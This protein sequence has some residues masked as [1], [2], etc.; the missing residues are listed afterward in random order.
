MYEI[1]G[2]IKGEVEV[3]RSPVK[4]VYFINY[5]GG[6]VF[7]PDASGVMPGIYKEIKFSGRFFNNSIRIE[8]I[9]VVK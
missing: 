1:K 2:I 5:L 3:V 8:K 7:V 9:E 6:R 4:G